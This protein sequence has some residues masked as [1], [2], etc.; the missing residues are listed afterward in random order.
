MS[1]KYFLHPSHVRLIV[2]M[3]HTRLYCSATQ[4]PLSR[5]M[6][7]PKHSDAIHPS[8]DSESGSD[9][10]SSSS[11][12]ESENETSSDGSVRMDKLYETH[13]P[14]TN[15]QKLLLSV[16]SSLAAIIDPYTRDGKNL[17]IMWI[18]IIYG[19]FILY[20]LFV[21]M[22]TDMVAVFGETTGRQA[23]KSLER[24]MSLSTEGL[25]ILSDRPVLNSS[26]MNQDEL[27]NLPPNTFGYHYVKFMDD[28][29]SLDTNSTVIVIH[30]RRKLLVIRGNQS[31]LWTT[32]HWLIL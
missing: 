29:V 4:S 8:S 12:S 20:I 18:L 23:L 7:G 28:N 32:R 17:V 15:L 6:N 2:S 22:I 16:G 19:Y 21:I 10:S 3:V 5:K 1:L 31:S 11:D 27:W 30:I 9:S 13:I 24:R 14:T 26:T 25:E